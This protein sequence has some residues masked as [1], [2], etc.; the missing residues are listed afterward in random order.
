VCLTQY[1]TG[2]VNLGCHCSIVWLMKSWLRSFDAA[3][4]YIGAVEPVVSIS[5]INVSTEFTA[6]CFHGNF[7]HIFFAPYPIS[8]WLRLIERTL[9]CEIGIILNYLKLINKI[10]NRHIQLRLFVHWI[11]IIWHIKCFMQTKYEIQ[12]QSETASPPPRGIGLG[13]AVRTGSGL[14]IWTSDPHY[15]QNLKDTFLSNDTYVM[16]ISWKSSHSIRRYKPNCIKMP[17]LAISKNL[18]KNSWISIRKR[19]TFKNLIRSSS[20]KGT[21]VVNF[22]W[23]SVQ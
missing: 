9:S 2:E 12:E 19:M 3:T 5:L 20:T 22:S 14:W 7:L 18:S 16:K 6:R 17:H 1:F 23:R 10:V 8:L 4:S 15:L 13:S 11:V 21:S